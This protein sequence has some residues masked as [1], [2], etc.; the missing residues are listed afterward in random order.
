MT[1]SFRPLLPV[2]GVLLAAFAWQAGANSARPPAQPTAVATVDI[3]QIID[4]LDERKVRENELE[5]NKS[6]RQA[7]V[8]E[9][10]KQLKTLRADLESLNPGTDEYKEKIREGMEMEAVVKARGDALNTILSIDRGN[11][12]REMYNKITEA[13]N[14]IA[15][16]EGYD[17]VLFDDSLFPVPQDAPFADIYRAIITRGVIYR[18]DSIDI[19][20]EVVTLM[21]NEFTAP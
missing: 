17:I 18:H 4:Q 10:V 1:K 5:A 9:V 8:D 15:E 14:R 12:T 2:M 3:V 21:N 7:Q 6:T 19:T 13:I 16:R 11:V 20:N